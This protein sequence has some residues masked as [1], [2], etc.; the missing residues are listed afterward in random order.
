MLRR[1][2]AKEDPQEFVDDLYRRHSVVL[3]AFFARRT[4]EVQV[5]FDLTAE[6]F[7]TALEEQP[8]CSARTVSARRAWLFGIA[9][10]LLASF[11]R[12]GEIELRAVRRLAI[13]TPLM[14]DAS[15]RRVEDLAD[16]ATARLAMSHAIAGL[17]DEYREALRLRVIDQRPYV[18]VARELGIT[19]QTAR[20]RVSRA[21][22]S[23]RE[24]LESESEFLKEAIEGV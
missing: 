22:K 2:T 17:S 10:N 19:E 14:S 13:E 3:L 21:L 11:Y 4:Y 1:S 20:A 15:I 5:A 23:L 12:S 6:T 18:D 16:L 8:N 9:R 24:S 7:A